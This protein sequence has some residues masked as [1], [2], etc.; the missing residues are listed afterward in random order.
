MDGVSVV[1]PAFHAQATISRA[2]ASAL[3]QDPP[4]EEIIVVADDGANYAPVL[5]R[6]GLDDRRLHNLYG[7]RDFDLHWL[8]VALAG[9]RRAD[10]A[11]AGKQ[12]HAPTQRRD[13]E[14]PIR[15]NRRNPA[16]PSRSKISASD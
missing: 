16:S 5:A 8:A 4:P 1:I 14:A 9:L 2:V 6:V 3:C 7:L 11:D 10:Q 15:G 13:S 12:E